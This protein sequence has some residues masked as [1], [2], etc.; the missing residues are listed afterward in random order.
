[1]GYNLIHPQDCDTQIMIMIY[2]YNWKQQHN[3]S[4]IGQKIK[5]TTELI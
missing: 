5:E 3:D 2:M 1:M 4:K